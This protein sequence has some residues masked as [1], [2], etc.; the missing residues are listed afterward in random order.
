MD[1]SNNGQFEEYADQLIS[2][3]GKDPEQF[4]WEWERQIWA[5]LD[6]IRRDAGRFKDRNNESVTPVFRLVEV[7]MKIL[8]MCGED[9]FRRYGPVTRAMLTS[10]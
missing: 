6:I 4:E 8:K 3:A 2:L 1:H 5:W 10:E 9:F 7:A